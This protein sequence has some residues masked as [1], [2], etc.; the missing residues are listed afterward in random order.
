MIAVGISTYNRKALAL[1][2]LEAV[3]QYAGEDTII[4]IADDGSTD[5]TPAAISDFIANVSSP[6]S[7]IPII[8]IGRKEHRGI[9]ATKKSLTDQLLATKEVTD[10][11][12]IEDDVIP[13]ADGWMN[14][15]IETARANLQAHLLYLPTTWKY[16]KTFFVTG[17]EPTQVEWKV[18][19]SGLVMYFRA[20]LLREIGTFD[21]RFGH[22]GF[23]HNELTSRALAAQGQDPE[24]YPH[25]AW[26]EKSNSLLALDII[27]EKLPYAENAAHNKLASSKMAM[28]Q[29]NKP[30]YERLMKDHRNKFNDD[31]RLVVERSKYFSL[32]K[33]PTDT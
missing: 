31:R 19:A 32:P 14:K 18:Y 12:L 27:E 28:A 3:W 24:K 8:F 4:A 11:L 9:A 2:C 26:A 6:L 23:E 15:F 30:L 13:I 16:G 1:R 20:S 10:L 7:F 5:G 22:Y 21:E 33:T 25:C 29:Q 17:S